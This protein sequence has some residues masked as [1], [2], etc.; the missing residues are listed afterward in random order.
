VVFLLQ[1]YPGALREGNRN[2]LPLAVFAK[3]IQTKG[4]NSREPIFLLLAN[5]YPDGLELGTFADHRNTNVYLTFTSPLISIGNDIEI[6][7]E[8]WKQV[9]K[10]RPEVI[11]QCDTH[12]PLSIVL[13]KSYF[14]NQEW[15]ES[16]IYALKYTYQSLFDYM[17]TSRLTNMVA[18]YTNPFH[19]LCY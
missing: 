7:E 18:K 2:Y 15:T 9:A 3:H 4:F 10:I 12:T 13:S 1:K 19:Q 17:C 14:E 11:C 16:S 6:S 5:S 8:T